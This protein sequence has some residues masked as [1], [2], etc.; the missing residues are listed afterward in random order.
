MDLLDFILSGVVAV[1]LYELIKMKIQIRLKMRMPGE[2]FLVVVQE[3]AQAAAAPAA[4]RS[5]TSTHRKPMPRFWDMLA[6]DLKIEAAAH[7][8]EY[9]GVKKSDLIAALVEHYR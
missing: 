9:S 6:E 3:K 7:G 8:Q 1:A 5:S 2:S 4:S